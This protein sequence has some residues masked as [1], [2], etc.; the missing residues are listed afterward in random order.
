MQRHL[1]T[2]PGSEGGSIQVLS[3]LGVTLVAGPGSGPDATYAA[4]PRWGADDWPARLS[5]TEEHLRRA[6]AWPSLLLCEGLEQPTMLSHELE[7]QGWVR[8]T[9]ETTMWVGH[10]S[11]VPHLDP[12][13][14]IEAVQ[15]RSLETHEA[16]ERHIFGIGD[17]HAGQRRH[18]MAV[19]LEAGRL[20]AWIIWLDQE[21]VAVARLA[22]GVG[23][24]GLQGIGV[25][26]TRRGQGYGTLMTTIATRAGMAVGNRLI[27]LSVRDDNAVARRVYERL[28]FR[29]AFGWSRWLVTQDPRAR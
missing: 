13:M 16:L 29:P 17:E 26:E 18:A 10:A 14:R 20:R 21:P 1:V 19:E 11:V 4:M 22:Q 24:A 25:T 27:W 7:R 28:G 9:S 3:E 15:P 8:V 5:A 2:L 12:L 23:A 6:G